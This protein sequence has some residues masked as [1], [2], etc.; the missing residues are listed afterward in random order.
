MKNQSV[1]SNID[2]IIVTIYIVLVILGWL[3]IYSSSLPVE[4][5]HVFSFGEFY[6][7]QLIFILL[8]IPLIFILL[9]VDGKVYE[10]FSSIFFAISLLSLA[11]LFVF[12]KTIKGQANW[13]SFGSFGIQP[14]EFAKSAT[15]LAIAKYLSDVQINLKDVNRQIQALGILF[16]P[17]LLILP[18]DPGSALIYSVFLFVFYREGLPAWYLWTAF[19]TIVLFVMTLV[20]EPH[21]VVLTALIVILLQ[22]LKSR[23]AHRNPILSGLIFLVITGFVYSV[24]YVFEN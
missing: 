22:Y 8:T 19:I 18:H 12:G 4:E 10:K 11:G 24:N 13:Y 6:G 9:S 16:L 3:N 5:E 15:A 1:R 7:K 23:A 21:Y 20:F 17:V 2:W 14:S